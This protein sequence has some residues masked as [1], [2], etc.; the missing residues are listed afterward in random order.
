MEQKGKT[1]GIVGGGQ[2]GRMLAQ[3]SHTLGFKVIILD[4]T[5]NSP[6]AQ[7]ADEQIIGSYKDKE[8]VIELGRK[9]DYVTFEIEGTNEEALILS[10]IHI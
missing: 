4:E 10:L 1:I 3:A 6:A 5:T 9:S 7:I 8:K 2:L